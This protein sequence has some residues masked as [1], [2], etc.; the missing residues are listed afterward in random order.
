MEGGMPL[1]VVQKIL[2]HPDVRTTRIYLDATRIGLHESMQRFEQLRRESC[3]DVAQDGST[4]DVGA[5][6]SH[7]ENSMDVNE[8]V[9][10]AGDGDRTRDIELGKLAFYR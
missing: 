8:L 6:A 5:D 7:D 4:N 3:T 2:G 1:K 9:N 10:G